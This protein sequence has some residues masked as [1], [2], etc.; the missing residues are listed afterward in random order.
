[1]TGGFNAR[2]TLLWGDETSE[3]EA[4]KLV[5]DFSNV[6]LLE[7]LIDEPTHLPRDDIATC[8]DLIFTS[9]RYAFIFFFLYNLGN[10]RHTA[11]LQFPRTATRAV[12]RA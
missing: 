12:R 2:S 6:N 7:Q 10:N 8:I 4:G 9:D 1:M 5:A 3:N 11:R